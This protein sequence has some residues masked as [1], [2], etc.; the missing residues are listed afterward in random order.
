MRGARA[1]AWAGAV[2]VAG[3]LGLQWWWPPASGSDALDFRYFEFLF[4]AFRAEVLVHGEFP[5]WNPY[6]CGGYVLHANPQTPFL[7]PLAWPALAIG[8]VPGLKLFALAHLVI[9]V[10]G[11]LRLGRELGVGG[12]ASWLLVFVFAGSARFAWVLQGGQFAMLTYA[13]LPWLLALSL[14]AQADLRAAAWAGVVLALMVLEGGTSGVPLGVLLVAAVAIA[15]FLGRRL[16]PRPLAVLGITLAVGFLLSLPKTWP[17][18]AYLADHPRPVAP[19]DD[20]LS[21]AQV[22]RMFLH[23]RAAPSM[24]DAAADP[25]L[26]GLHYRWW[27]EYGAYLGPL[28]PALAALGLAFRARK[29]VLWFALAALFFLVVLGQHGAVWPYDWLRRLPVYRDLRVPSRAAI[30]VVLMLAVL[31]AHGLDEMRARARALPD[32]LRALRAV[33]WLVVALVAADLVVFSNQVLATIGKRPPATEPLRHGPLTAVGPAGT[34]L[35]GAARRGLAS[36]DCY[37]PLFERTS[38]R[39]PVHARL[40]RMRH[41]VEAP[42]RARLTLIDWTPNRVEFL[43]ELPRE[44]TV[45]VRQGHDRGW[46]GDVGEVVDD[47]GVLGVRLP[48]G[49]HV[50]TLRHFPPGLAWGA[51]VATMIAAALLAWGWRRPRPPGGG[52][53]RPPTARSPSCSGRI[54]PSASW[55]KSTTDQVLDGREVTRHH[56]IVDRG[57]SDPEAAHEDADDQ[58]NPPAS[59][60]G[61]LAHQERAG[62]V[63]AAAPSGRGTVPGGG[64]LRRRSDTSH[65]QSPGKMDH[66]AAR[67]GGC[68]DPR[69]AE[70]PRASSAACRGI[71]AR[72]APRSSPRSASPRRP[73]GPGAGGVTPRG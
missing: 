26:A 40:A 6:A 41:A 52:A 48:A 70:Y 33:P 42:Q 62:S 56:L 66:L 24:I 16:D 47:R 59:A 71:R 19:Q 64:P 36:L 18:L 58:E 9:A 35:A 15:G 27:G 37:D 5:S 72:C 63:G 3:A 53:R 12:L 8:A 54:H 55:P 73:V 69:S 1:G 31:A 7:S 60:Q 50:V 20:A 68:G 13:F 4:E 51:V 14:R 22:A 65:V 49:T 44:T 17:V 21:L 38:Y 45:L 25:A 39:S 67:Y 23:R 10:L 30:L 11:T 28:V 61:V 43:A 32:R 46:T 57:R 2:L 34:D 29:A